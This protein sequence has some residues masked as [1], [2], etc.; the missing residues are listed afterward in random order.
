MTAQ[1]VIKARRETVCTVCKETIA[2]GTNTAHRPGFGYVHHPKCANVIPSDAPDWDE[3]TDE[4]DEPAEPVSPAKKSE[5]GTSGNF[6]ALRRLLLEELARATADQ[7]RLVTAIVNKQMA[8]AFDAALPELL[9]QVAV[10]VTE[11]TD[12]LV[13]AKM[14]EARAEFQNETKRA[15]A[16]IAASGVVRQEITITR[17]DGTRSELTGEVFHEDF[18]WILQLASAG[19]PIFLPGP[20]G[21]GKTHVA[22]QVARALLGEQWKDRFG[23]LSCSPATSER[24]FLGRSIPNITTGQDVY[25]AAE[26]VRLYEEGGVFVADEIDAADASVLLVFNAAIANGYL[27]VPDRVEKPIAHRHPEFVFVACANTWGRGADRMYVGRNRLDEATLDRFRVGTVPLDYSRA[28]E[29]SQCP[30]ADL[31]ELLSKW[32]EAI[33]ANRLERVLSTRFV[34]D[35]YH[36]VR[37]GAPVWRIAKA[38]FGG[39]RDDETRKVLGQTLPEYLK[40][41]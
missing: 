24:H 22:A 35:A 12:A 32:R 27:P 19:K 17:P 10:A 20:T 8:G 18:A 11:S 30:D 38:F 41:V 21:C 9:K 26:F 13:A 40:A 25:R 28:I 2:I 31:Y 4:G 34:I 3:L 39:W 36:M 5:P 33:Y 16:A 6:D 14:I 23:I 1:R 37:A 15:I 7:T 29:M